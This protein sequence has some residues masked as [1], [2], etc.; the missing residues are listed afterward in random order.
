MHAQP[1]RTARSVVGTRK[2]LGTAAGLALLIWALVSVDD[3]GSLFA[4]E[5]AFEKPGDFWVVFFPQLTA[6]VGF[7]AT[8]SLNI[9]DFTRYVRSQR[10]QVLGQAFGLPLFMT[11]FSFL[12]VAVTSA[13]VGPYV[14]AAPS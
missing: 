8:L 5:S 7:W 3:R 4:T 11:L 1:S 13:T 9:P 14:A 2:L 6:M 10:D 12:G